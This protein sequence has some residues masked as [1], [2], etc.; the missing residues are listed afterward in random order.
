MGDYASSDLS[1][2]VEQPEQHAENRADEDA[3]DHRKI[4]CRAVALVHDVARQPAKPDARQDRP[5]DP[6]RQDHKSQADQEPLHIHR[7]VLVT[8]YKAAHM[9]VLGRDG[10]RD[11]LQQRAETRN[12]QNKNR[13]TA[14]AAQDIDGD[15]H[16]TP[17][18]A[19]APYA[20]QN[21]AEHPA[22]ASICDLQAVTF[23]I[24]DCAA[25]KVEDLVVGHQVNQAQSR[26]AKNSKVEKSQAF[27]LDSAVR[28]NEDG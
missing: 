20:C 2:S 12:R 6:D 21:F 28:G 22:P 26:E 3:G 27:D 17:P 10:L 23:A 24:H 5:H 7:S 18:H 15:Q 16:Q 14:P 8:E 9:S 1:L 11:D 13:K 19:G 25:G 4:K